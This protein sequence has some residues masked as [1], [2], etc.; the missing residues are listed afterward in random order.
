MAPLETYIAGDVW[1]STNTFENTST[2]E[3]VDPSTVMF[4]YSIAGADPVYFNYGVGGNP[5][6]IRTG[7]GDYQISIDTTTFATAETG[8]VS[9]QYLWASQSAGPT[10]PARASG[11]A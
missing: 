5:H 7:T 11:R 2:G 9:V 10:S 8:T 3:P 1:V 6:I 4:S